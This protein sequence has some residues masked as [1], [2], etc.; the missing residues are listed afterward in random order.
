MGEFRVESENGNP[1]FTN[2]ENRPP[3]YNLQYAPVDFL[4][5]S[6]DETPAFPIGTSGGD[7]VNK[8]S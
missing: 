1:N 2:P 8:Y 3:T 4:I 6:V 7:I 5:A